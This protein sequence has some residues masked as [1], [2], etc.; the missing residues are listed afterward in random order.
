MSF[1]KWT[2]E[3]SLSFMKKV[4][5]KTAIVSITSPGVYF[6]DNTEFSLEI[7]RWSNE[8]MAGLKKNFPGKFGAFVSIPPGFA[9][10]IY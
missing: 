2:P 9:D 10:T 7:S 8:Y 4:G 6:K 1:P 5:I 3:T